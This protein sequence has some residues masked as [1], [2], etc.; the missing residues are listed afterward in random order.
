MNKGL[1]FNIIAKNIEKKKNKE[2]QEQN[3]ILLEQIQDAMIE[4]QAARE[5]FDSVSDS[6]LVESAIYKEE[7][8]IKRYEYLI[9]VAKRRELKKY[10]E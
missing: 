4:M 9:N 6:K 10:I 1:I 5:L 3:N 8:A 2:Y 7:S